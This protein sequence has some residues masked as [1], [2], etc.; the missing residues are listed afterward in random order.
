MGLWDYSGVD[1][2]CYSD[3]NCES[4]KKAAA[5]LGETV[6]DWGCGTGWAKKYFENYR[7]I[8]G[9]PSAFLKETV[10]LVKYTSEVDNI[11]MRQVLELNEDW[12]E[13]LENVKKSFRKKFCLIIYTPQIKKTRIGHLHIPV[14]ADGSKMKGKVISEIYFSKQDILA[15]FP[16]N[17]Y[18]LMEEY[19]ETRQGYFREWI[20]YVEKL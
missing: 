3:S 13:I 16:E 6:E 11:L 7:G 15:F 14:R 18:R 5:F 2:M 8:D 4:Y 1:Q 9:S 17:E 12:R 10:D 19:I 20:L